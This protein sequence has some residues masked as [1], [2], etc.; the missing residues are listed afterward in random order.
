MPRQKPFSTHFDF[1]VM[2]ETPKESA[3]NRMLGVF[4]LGYALWRLTM[5]VRRSK[6]KAK[7]ALFVCSFRQTLESGGKKTKNQFRLKFHLL[8]LL[9]GRRLVFYYRTIL[10]QSTIEQ[11][12]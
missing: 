7:A 5:H 10:Q 4:D 8:S 2:V 3:A 9:L 1:H 11:V 6:L 12:D